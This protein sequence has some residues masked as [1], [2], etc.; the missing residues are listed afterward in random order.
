MVVPPSPS[1]SR[2]SADGNVP[3]PTFVKIDV[4]GGEIEVLKG[5]ENVITQARPKMVI[6]THGPECH[7]FVL[8]FLGRH[9]YSYRILNP[10]K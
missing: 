7:E 2:V 10:E 3:L 5:L 8:K 4:E 9:W 6:A 1:F